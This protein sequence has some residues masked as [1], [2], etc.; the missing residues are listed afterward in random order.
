[1]PQLLQVEVK[2]HTIAWM[3]SERL[4]EGDT[5]YKVTWSMQGVKDKYFDNVDTGIP[6][7]LTSNETISDDFK[8]DFLHARR[9]IGAA[10]KTFSRYFTELQYLNYIGTEEK[11]SDVIIHLESNGNYR[12]KI[13][14]RPKG[15]KVAIEVIIG[16]GKNRHVNA[17]PSGEVSFSCTIEKP[18]SC[19]STLELAVWIIKNKSEWLFSELETR[20]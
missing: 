1:M 14:I 8:N 5:R 2:N 3:K 12:G 16:N 11:I 10:V 7:Q 18:S 4:R 9:A 6:S 19:K 15:Q 17:Y 20:A 13:C